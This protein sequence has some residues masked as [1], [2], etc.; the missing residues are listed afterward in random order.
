M[1]A[2]SSVSY[3][4]VSSENQADNYSIP[5]QREAIEKYASEHNLEIV[6]EFIDPGV[7]GTTLNRPALNELRET[8]GSGE[9]IVCYDPDRLS[10]NFVNLMVLANEFE[11]SGIELTFVTQPVGKTPEDRMLFGMKGLFAEYERTKIL[12]RTARGRRMRVK[13]GRFP[14][15]STSKL[16]GY[17]YQVGSGIGEG[18]R[19]ID[20]DK[21]GVAKSIY[22]WFAEGATLRG[23]V[24]KLYSLSIPSPSGNP[25]WNRTTVFKML[26]NRAY[27]GVAE[28]C[29]IE[30]QQPPLITEDLFEIVQ[31]KLKR[32]K[33]LSSRNARREYLLSGY[34]FCGLCG[35]RYIGSAKVNTRYY[36]CGGSS[37]KVSIN[38]CP[39]R[40]LRADELEVA[41][42]NEVKRALLNPEVIEAGLNS[43]EQ[44]DTYRTELEAV[45][46]KLAHFNKEKDRCWNAY[47]I[48]GDEDTFREGI[49]NITENRSK[50]EKRHSELQSRIEAIQ[51]M[52]NIDDIRQACAVVRDNLGNLSF[53]DKRLALETLNIKICVS[54]KISIEG[55]LPIELTPS[56]HRHG[57]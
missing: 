18:I 33:E 41:V 12:E 11:K 48:T 24:S 7:S 3:L 56:K 9:T 22:T 40:G 21:A 50:L 29:G 4:R 1:K 34:V 2:V 25:I 55:V 30:I 23:I 54:D 51:R 43:L 49:Q 26:K 31:A 45:S 13:Q 16:Y 6:R 52:P 46:A 5:S 42:W 44:G 32:N 20:Q 17:T 36:F 28:V 14:G 47:L 10:R 8:I 38:P 15:G 27:T 53:K 37:E 39:T 19:Y 35:R 57:G